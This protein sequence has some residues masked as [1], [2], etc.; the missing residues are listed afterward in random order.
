M[1]NQVHTES[2][3]FWQCLCYTLCWS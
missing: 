3:F 1:T 2:S